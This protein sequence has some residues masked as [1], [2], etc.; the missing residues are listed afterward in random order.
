MIPGTSSLLFSGTTS[1][2]AVPALDG[3]RCAGGTSRRLALRQT[4]PNGEAVFAPT[5][6]VAAWVQGET[7]HFLA[8]YRDPSGPCG[9]A[10][11]FTSAATVTFTP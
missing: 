4:C 10:A 7:L 3:I 5:E 1:G 6:W 11:S 8:M 9:T 2:P